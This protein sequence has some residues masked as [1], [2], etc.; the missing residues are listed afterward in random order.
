MKITDKMKEY[1]YLKE[2]EI[3][4]KDIDNK[5][6]YDYLIPE[7]WNVLS[8]NKKIV[9]IEYLINIEAKEMNIIEIPKLMIEENL[10]IAGGYEHDTNTIYIIRP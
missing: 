3:F 4:L 8:E 2:K 10:V 6:I 9:I 5:N 7:K 1:L